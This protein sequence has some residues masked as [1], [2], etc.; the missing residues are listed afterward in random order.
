MAFVCVWESNAWVWFCE[1]FICQFLAKKGEKGFTQMLCVW[2]LLFQIYFRDV[3]E[4]VL[5]LENVMSLCLVIWVVKQVVS[6]DLS[7]ILFVLCVMKAITDVSFLEESSTL[8]LDLSWKE[9]EMCWERDSETSLMQPLVF[10]VKTNAWF[11]GECFQPVRNVARSSN[12]L[13]RPSKS[14]YHEAAVL[15]WL[16]HGGWN[17]SIE[18]WNCKLFCCYYYLGCIFLFVLAKICQR[19]RMLVLYFMVGINF[20]KQIIATIL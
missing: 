3:K 7:Y 19:G 1:G 4:D 5:T 20:V 8:F 2:S 10:F 12:G 18:D 13:V 15:M 11:E 17:E 6:C 9:K 16:R 14:C